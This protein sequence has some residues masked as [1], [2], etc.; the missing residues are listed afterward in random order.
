MVF[1]DI[2]VL[3][4]SGNVR[5]VLD[6]FGLF[7]S[8]I[9]LPI[10]QAQKVV[11]NR[12]NPTKTIVQGVSGV[13]F[14][15]ETLLVLGQ[16]GSGCSTTLK[17]IANERE[18]YGKVDGNVAYSCISSEE[19]HRKYASE[20]LYNDE[21]D[22]HYPNLKVKHT[23]DF[24][25]RLR[26]PAKN[27]HRDTTSFS[28]DMSDRL[29]G[30][31][32]MSHTKDTIVGSS[33][34]RGVSGGERKRVSL[35]EVM[36]S[37]PA[38]ACWDNPIR[39][40]DSSSAL[41]FLKLLKS[42]SQETKMANIVTIYQ[43]SDAM[44]HQCFDR[45]L[46]MYEGRMIFSGKAQD[47]QD[48]FVNL[49]FQKL[50]RQTTPDFLTSV[51]ASS[52]RVVRHDHIGPVPQT[53]E[54]F[55]QAFF[56][57]A[58][59]E[60]LQA[61][62]HAYQQAAATDIS[63]LAAFHAEVD[64]VKASV[65]TKGSLEPT[66]IWTQTLVAMRRYYQ[67]LWVNQYDLYIVL[68]L[69]AVNAVINGSAY[70]K[71]PQTATGSFEK[72]GALFFSL[73]YFFLNALSEVSSTISARSI[74]IKQHK[75]GLIHPTAFVIAQTMADIPV[76][77]FQ[78][79]VFSCCY[80]FMLGLYKSASEFWIFEL[81]L[82]VHYSAVSSMFRMLGAWAPSLDIAFLAAGSALPIC[83]NYAGYGPPV[84]TMHRWGSW[85]RR[86]SPS[87]WALEA[88]MGNEFSNIDLH[89]TPD[90][91]VPSGPGYGEMQYQGCSLPGSS[92]GSDVV[93]GSTYLELIYR[94]TRSNLWRNFGI[95]LVMW[96]LYVVLTAVGL[97][98]MTG[99]SGSGG[100]PIFKRG[101][102]VHPQHSTEEK[103]NRDVEQ[104]A[105]SRTASLHPVSSSSSVTQTAATEKQPKAELDKG[106]FSFKDVS[107]F[108]TVDGEERKLLNNIN[109]YVK[110][111]QLTALMGSSG[112]GKTT[113]LDTISQRKSTGKVEG[114]MLI[115]GRPLDGTF[116]RSCGFCMQQDVHEPMATV[117]EALEFSA[118]LRQPA[119][120]PVAEKLDYVNHII[121]LLELEPI[122]DAIIGEPG[123]GGL[124]VEERKRVTI[125]VELAA[126]P[127]ALLF[128]DEVGVFESRLKVLYNVN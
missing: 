15:G 25:L 125:G 52:E 120:V 74:L 118:K 85:I 111:G 89:C 36:A 42:L 81:I 110:P 2:C 121:S 29:L 99:S 34:V 58:Y 95:I 114:Q 18:S 49:G 3:C 72:G 26:K 24:A 10:H 79:L 104:T 94:Y 108:V 64:R 57:S 127:S 102:A 63:G 31:L 82:F 35:A 37:N 11:G 17:V 83:L 12:Q 112:A 90:Q 51:T 91:M 122:A 48:H 107:Y 71:A 28:E 1:E 54:Q 55:A 44:Y 78:T 40:L 13:V 115:G 9:K 43:A 88:L 30:S 19:M 105:V 59:Y 103:P 47:A 66:P 70:Y 113:L 14:P 20:V 61:D 93:S 117:R 128:L 97:T 38:I 101:A 7:E 126:K 46:V 5:T 65:T 116:S 22:I 92:K 80:Y 84:P 96:F 50:G 76:A 109:G 45:V 124:N 23:L 41:Q 21:D 56:Q 62:I 68:F 73:I 119:H 100:G 6:L 60:R 106:T 123:D 75:L 86:I 98:V 33:F 27:I 32:G 4:T 16:P 39:G 77:A 53:P 67:L 8:I 87:P 69:N